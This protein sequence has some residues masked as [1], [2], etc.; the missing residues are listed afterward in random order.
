MRTQLARTNTYTRK[1]LSTGN[2]L[3]LPLSRACAKQYILDVPIEGCRA[4]RT[5]Q[6]VRYVLLTPYMEEM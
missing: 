1:Y 6:Y 3:T 4:H 5:C 2:F